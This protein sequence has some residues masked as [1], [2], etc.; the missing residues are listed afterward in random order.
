[1]TNIDIALV[2]AFSSKNDCTEWFRRASGPIDVAPHPQLL[3]LFDHYLYLFLPSDEPRERIADVVVENAAI[4]MAYQQS[5]KVYGEKSIFKER[6]Q[7]NIIANGIDMFYDEFL[8]RVDPLLVSLA[9]NGV[10]YFHFCVEEPDIVRKIIDRLIF[11]SSVWRNEYLGT[12]T[13]STDTILFPLKS[14]PVE[15]SSYLVPCVGNFDNGVMNRGDGVC[16]NKFV[17]TF[18]KEGLR[19]V[20]TACALI[21]RDSHPNHYY[22]SHTLPTGDTSVYFKFL[23]HGVFNIS[24]LLEVFKRIQAISFDTKFVLSG[25]DISC[26]VEEFR[27]AISSTS[28]PAQYNHYVWLLLCHMH[29]K[30]KFHLNDVFNASTPFRA[31]VSSGNAIGPAMFN[32]IVLGDKESLIK[33]LKI[34][35]FKRNRNFGGTFSSESFAT[36][37]YGYRKL[38][39]G[40]NVKALKIQRGILLN[41]LSAG[42]GDIFCLHP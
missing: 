36:L 30:G 22:S 12:H 34:F 19:N 26:T 31:S 3:K 33:F 41:L 29:K 42:Y 32:Y 40:L 5:Y 18:L 10:A 20:A 14:T 25:V 11:L 28:E 7:R 9:F 16:I 15:T 21:Y 8:L 2:S 35:Q 17:P 37:L 39:M 6:I 23:M 38:G 13:L 1:M 4:I 27:E 24:S